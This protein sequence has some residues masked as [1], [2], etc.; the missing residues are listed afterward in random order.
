MFGHESLGS[1]QVVAEVLAGDEAI[2][3]L[4]PLQRVVRIPTIDVYDLGCLQSL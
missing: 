4:D 3:L 2:L 1:L